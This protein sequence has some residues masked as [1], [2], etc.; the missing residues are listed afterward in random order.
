MEMLPGPVQAA[1]TI[2]LNGIPGGQGGK[3]DSAFRFSFSAFCPSLLF[4]SIIGLGSWSFLSSVR[5]FYPFMT[6]LS[7]WDCL[8]QAVGR[9]CLVTDPAV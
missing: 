3:E 6:D 7:P 1:S 8:F 2:V 9:H 4:H 5:I